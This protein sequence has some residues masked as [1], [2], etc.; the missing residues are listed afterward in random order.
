MPRQLSQN[1]GDG[2][3]TKSSNRLSK[4]R[5]GGLLIY[6]IKVPIG[7]KWVFKI[8]YKVDGNV[9]RYKAWLFS[10]GYT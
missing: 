9:E 7:C 4:I 6:H 10:R 3:F 1:I 2:L 5:I 8:K